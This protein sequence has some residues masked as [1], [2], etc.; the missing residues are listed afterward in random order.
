[1]TR[2][3]RDLG[4]CSAFLLLLSCHPGGGSMKIAR[5]VPESLGAWQP[6]EEPDEATYDRRTVFEY[7]DGAGEVFL[8]YAYREMF[9]RRLRDS[10]G[11]E[12]TL[13]VYDMGKP[14]DAFGIFTRF[15]TGE[16][17]GVGQGSSYVPGH[18]NFW[19]GRYFGS[20]YTLR[21]GDTA[22]A[23]VLE[24]GAA[25]AGAIPETGRPPALLALLPEADLIADS[26]RYF[27]T[28][29]ELNRH[30]FLSDRDL[31]E[32]AG[33]ADVA[34]GNYRR[35]EEYAY[36]FVVRYPE[37]KRAAAAGAAFRQVFLPED[38]GSGVALFEEGL[39]TAVAEVGE[40]LILV[41][42][43]RSRSRALGLRDRARALVE[44]A[45]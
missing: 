6:S 19:K 32:L 29:T 44:G 1:M 26:V 22:R 35:G 2:S 20:V 21:G 33:T 11:D 28:F 17:M 39:W 36:L 13:E 5:L 30:F 31:L 3:V 8:Q 45:R 41:F 9:V 37:K 18:L 40:H 14:A 16:E 7:M 4:C 15:R 23:A 10:T 24:A 43:A 42:D 25:I 34:L 12:M 27:H 38:D